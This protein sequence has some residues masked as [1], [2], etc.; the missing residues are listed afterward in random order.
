MFKSIQSYSIGWTV[1]KAMNGSFYSSIA[2]FTH[3]IGV[4]LKIYSL[5]IVYRTSWEICHHSSL[6]L[7][8]R[9]TAAQGLPCVLTRGRV[10][11]LAILGTIFCLSR[12]S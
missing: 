4:S 1:K 5:Y 7:G 10:L 2:K 12:M 3:G 11:T 6:T 8:E 9:S